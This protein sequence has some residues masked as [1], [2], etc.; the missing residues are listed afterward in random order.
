MYVQKYL[1]EKAICSRKEAEV[2]L[3]EGLI[4]INGKKA[5]PGVPLSPT[6]VVTLAPQAEKRLREKITIAIYKPR[7]IVCSNVE[8]EGRTVFDLFPQF[9]N[10]NTVG[11]LD[12]E[13]EG[14]LLLSNDGLITK[15]ITGDTHDVE[16]EYE[17][18]VQEHVS[19]MKLV[20]IA[21]GLMLSDG[22]TLPAKVHATSRHSFRIILREGRNRQIRRMCGA[23]DLT[24]TSLK[25]IR[26]G[27]LTLGTLRPGNFRKLEPEEVEMLRRANQE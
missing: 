20:P 15:R 12:K 22:Q 17:V 19:N 5:K 14:L 11:R 13:S 7:G 2:F 6:D 10:L 24:V 4:L 9:K 1:V 8:E 25:R 21:E 3:R 26:I 18:E 23:V 27:E 16:K